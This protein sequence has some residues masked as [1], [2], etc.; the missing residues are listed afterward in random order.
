M[1]GL[2]RRPSNS[3]MA[4]VKY[5]EKYDSVAGGTLTAVQ[6]L[7]TRIDRMAERMKIPTSPSPIPP[8]PSPASPTPS[9]HAELCHISSGG[10][11][12]TCGAEVLIEISPDPFPPENKP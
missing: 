11:L 7:N 12:C 6:S 5:R 10:T 4:A 2:K 9:A 8:K 3:D 1:S